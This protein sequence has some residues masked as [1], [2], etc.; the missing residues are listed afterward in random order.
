M[1][2]HRAN[3]EWDRSRYLAGRSLR[4]L[5]PANGWYLIAVPNTWPIIETAAERAGKVVNTLAHVRIYA[6]AL[7]A[8]SVLVENKGDND[9]E[10]VRYLLANYPRVE[11]YGYSIFQLRG[12]NPSGRAIPTDTQTSNP[13]PALF[14]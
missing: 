3:R 7:T 6:A 12:G 11:R 14:G 8:D 13:P 1:A 4:E 2:A 9:R 5:V 10:M